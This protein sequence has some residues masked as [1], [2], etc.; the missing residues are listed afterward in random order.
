MSSFGGK[1]DKLPGIVCDRFD[2]LK[3]NSDVDDD[4]VTEHFF[5]SHCHQERAVNLD[6]ILRISRIALMKSR[7]VD[8]TMQDLVQ[9]STNTT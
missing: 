4:V 2:N 6:W 5:L 8:C 1:F 7:K 9:S 3:Q